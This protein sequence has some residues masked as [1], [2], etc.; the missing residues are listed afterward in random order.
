MA[1]EEKWRKYEYQ[2]CVIL[3]D[4]ENKE[5]KHY[6]WASKEEIEE[7]IRTIIVRMPGSIGQDDC[8]EDRF[9]YKGIVN[10]TDYEIAFNPK[11]VGSL[12]FRVR[13]VKLVNDIIS[14]IFKK[15]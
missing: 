11:K 1:Y 7:V 12:E 3:T 4:G 15:T 6:F 13:D 10:G 8:D 9:V 14:E 5:L 2:Y